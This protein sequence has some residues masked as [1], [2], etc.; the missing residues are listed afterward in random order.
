MKNCIAF[1]SLGLLIINFFLITN[2]SI[3]QIK[4]VRFVGE[5]IRNQVKLVWIIDQWNPS[6]KGFKIAKRRPLNLNARWELVSREWIYPSIDP[7]RNFSNQVLN[8]TE[9]IRIRAKMNNWLGSGKVKATS[10]N[11]FCAR[12]SESSDAVKGLNVSFGLDVDMAFIQGF[13]IID[14]T[15]GFN[16][17]EYGLFVLTNQSSE[18]LEPIK[19][20]STRKMA[21]GPINMDL[22]VSASGPSKSSNTRIKWMLNYTQYIQFGVNG[23]NIYKIEPKKVT[24]INKT[25]VWVYSATESAEGSIIDP[26]STATEKATYAVAPVSLFGTEGKRVI[27]EYVPPRFPEPVKMPKI[28]VQGKSVTK[29]IPIGWQF[30]KTDESQITGF[31]LQRSTDK[32]GWKTVSSM[33]PPDLRQ[34]EDKKIS[35]RESNTYYY[36]MLVIADKDTLGISG[37]VGVYHEAV[38]IPP[39]PKGLSGQVIRE[40]SKY[41]VNLSWDSPASGDEDTEEYMIYASFPPSKEILLMGNISPVK[42]NKFRYEIFNTM[43]DEYMFR[44]SARGKTRMESRLSDTLKVYVPG[45]YVL[46]PSLLPVKVDS[47]F[48]TITWKHDYR[49][50]LKGFQIFINGNPVANEEVLNA[51]LSSY[52]TKLEYGNSYI[53]E[54]VA[55]NRFGQKSDRSFKR[56]VS[57]D[58]RTR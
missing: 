10:T 49:R 18:S 45:N 7:S 27:Y 4:N 56:I 16:E 39:I 52:S 1:R 19:T 42:G 31:Y 55:V 41:V 22:K 15:E 26:T 53:I 11:E 57:V 17:W 20:I 34:F 46:S 3:G 51:R 25:P 8:E 50:D 43:G 47:N 13:G 29:N 37:V 9:A 30:L 14:Y 12:L 36:R 23:F 32:E 40:G 6:W 5:N 2:S 44:I 48:V 21:N 33:L 28:S 24:K 38:I 58:K 54:M 35:N